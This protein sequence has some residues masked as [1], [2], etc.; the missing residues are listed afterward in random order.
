MLFYLSRESFRRRQIDE[1]WK[2]RLATSPKSLAQIVLSPTVITE[3]RR[4]LKRS[5][6]HTADDADVIRLLRETVVRPD[7]L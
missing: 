7:V 5:T 1:L 4:E 3:I 2:A 6:G